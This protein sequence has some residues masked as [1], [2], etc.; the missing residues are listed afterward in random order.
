MFANANVNAQHKDS[1]KT[2]TNETQTN[3]SASSS[4]S[5]RSAS[6]GLLMSSTRRNLFGIRL[7][8]DQL[9]QDLKDMWQESIDRQNQNWGFDFQKLKPLEKSQAIEKK[10]QSPQKPSRFEWSKVSTKMN[11]FYNETEL[12]AATF[13]KQELLPMNSDYE[14][15]EE[16]EDDALVIPTFYKYQRRQKINEEQNRLKLI[17]QLTKAQSK[18]TKGSSNNAF[19]KMNNS[20][21]SNKIVHKPSALKAISSSS[22]QKKTPLKRSAIKC[23]N[24]SLIL[25]FSENRKDTLRSAATTV[26][27]ATSSQA[28][29]CKNLSAM[30]EKSASELEHSSAFKQPLKQQSLLDMLK[31]RKRKTTTADK[32][33]AKASAA[34]ASQLHNL[35]PRATSFTAN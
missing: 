16:E 17:S 25:T 7:N 34:Q 11:K 19:S 2:L 30:F 20:A 35:R 12:K 23:G 4:S 33:Q 28:T 26:T 29:A 3:T 15:E 8:H 1:D 24:R 6:P 5:S 22:T 18:A 21:G 10:Q 32:S 9:A 14:T 13:D 27:M 31:Q